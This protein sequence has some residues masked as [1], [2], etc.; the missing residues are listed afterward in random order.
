MLSIS[1]K[2]YKMPGRNV[3]RTCSASATPKHRC[4]SRWLTA[5]S[6]KP[7]P[8]LLTTATEEKSLFDRS[9]R[10]SQVNIAQNLLIGRTW[11]LMSIKLN[12][13]QESHRRYHHGTSSTC[14][15][16]VRA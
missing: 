10:H 1:S 4:S 16:A 5:S 2:C 3:K 11:Q 8:H 12:P 15:R 14:A 7:L 9:N 13:R 6:Q